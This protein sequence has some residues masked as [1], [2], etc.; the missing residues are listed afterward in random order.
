MKYRLNEYQKTYFFYLVF[1][2]LSC[3]SSHQ[4]ELSETYDI[5]LVKKIISLQKKGD[6]KS[7]IL[8]NE[9]YLKIVKNKQYKDGIALYYINY[10]RLYNTIGDY[11]KVR[12]FLNKAKAIS[13]GSDNYLVKTCYYMES[14]IL[15]GEFRLS[16]QAFK[17][18]SKAINY[19]KR[20]NDPTLRNYFL[21]QAYLSQGGEMYRLNQ[22]DSSLVYYK[23]ALKISQTALNESSLAWIYMV[24]P[25]KLD[26]SFVYVN[27]SLERIKKEKEVDATHIYVYFIAGEY[28]KTKY[29][30]SK[31][32]NYYKKALE[33]SS[34]TN[35][36]YQFF[37]QYIY[38]SL[39]EIYKETGN[40][41]EEALALSKFSVLEQ[42]ADLQHY[43]VIN[44]M[45]RDSLFYNT[46]L[47]QKKVRGLWLKFGIFI[48]ISLV[49]LARLYSYTKILKFK[50]RQLKKEIGTLKIQ[51][52]DSNFK[53]V[54]ELAKKNHSSFLMK[55]QELYPSF[56][57]KLLYIRPDLS[58]SELIFCAML[59]LNFTSKEIAS[60]LSIQHVS[61][62]KRKNRLRKKLDIPMN[63]DLYQFFRQL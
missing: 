60:C 5:P 25:N 15:N 34:L 59:K 45:T 41:K 14:G 52:D 7:Y 27:R 6:K 44:L 29:E 24:S 11:K 48:T 26:S 53:M 30:Y 47:E 43:E 17:D 22:I 1:L 23:K 40:K 37:N 35:N 42:S 61:A 49:L 16:D 57:P 58:T 62:Q 28:Y 46:A 51:V 4:N 20:I 55:F 3:N 54:I 8:T 33:L 12:T 32:E 50:K 36:T 9:E 56:V 19:S 31:A 2:L 21:S 10:A 63:V 13:I 39:F 38:Q 18:N